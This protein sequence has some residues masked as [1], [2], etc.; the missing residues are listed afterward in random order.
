MRTAT[1]NWNAARS[2][3]ALIA[4]SSLARIG[5]AAAV[6]L[7]V[8]ESY[9]VGISREWALSYFDH[10]PLHV[11]L[12]RAW[13]TLAD[14][15]RSVVVRLPFVALFAGSTWLMYRLTARTYGERAGLWAA[16]ALNLTPV[17]TLSVAS[18][19]L[20]D[21]PL[22]LFSL[23]AATAIA[24][25]LL[26]EHSP[27]RPLAGWIA[28]GVA[29][30]LALLSKYTGVFVLFGVALF[31]VTA[32]AY[33]HYWA[34]AGPWLGG[35]ISA[36]VFAPVVVWNAQHQW[37][38]FA[39]QFGRAAPR[40]F[41]PT[42]PVQDIGGQLAYLAPW[43]AVPLIVVL[44]QA[45]RHGARDR[46]GWFFACLA[47]GPIALFTVVGLWSPVLAHWPMIGWLF[48]FPLLGAALAQ[49]E[50]S[51]P[52]LARAY[53]WVSVGL[54]VALLGIAVSQAR[55]G[56]ITARV[57]AWLDRDPTVDVLDWRELE[58][59]LTRRGL[60]RPATI[61]AT[62]SWIDGGKLNYALGGRYTVLC[63]CRDPRGFAFLPQ[64]GVQMASEV[65]LISNATRSD[66]RQ[67]LGAFVDDIGPLADVVLSRGGQPAVT[68]HVARGIGLKATY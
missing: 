50:V 30:G 8:D 58:P 44:V 35:L 37:A 61:L 47:I 42:W 7:S 48:V 49:L 14:S 36:A 67:T 17:F 26:V 39:F 57:P 51:W 24:D 64:Q 66:W 40:G 16:V 59:A 22:V 5:L 12:V 52:V 45:L 32:R 46:A 55:T 4:L 68:L 25:T 56:W 33:R 11:W 23:L 10:P 9:I 65:L 2:V 20:P 18:W 19:V 53:C 1:P 13:A 38:S 31:L 62:P 54:L 60:L 15:E 28:A 3:A 34:T 27:P 6:G 63:L 43:I 41:R 21:G 29:G